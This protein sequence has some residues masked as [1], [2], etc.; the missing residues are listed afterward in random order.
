MSIRL[1]IKVMLRRK[2]VTALLLLQLA[3]TLAL[4]L[5]SIVLADQ[6][7]ER[8]QEPTGLSLANTLVVQ[9]K[10]TVSTLR[11]YPA[12]GELLER[13]MA[14]LR[15]IPG[16][17][18][19]AYA[20]QPPLLWGGN[21]GNIYKIGDQERNNISMVPQYYTSADIFAVLGLT[22][23]AG[24]L[25]QPLLSSTSSDKGG[26][27]ITQSVAKRLFHGEEAI[28]QATNQGTIAAVVSD[29][30]GQR[31]ADG[32][33]YNSIFVAPL[34]GVDWGYTLLLRADPQQ[35]ASVRLQLDTVLRQVDS[36]IEIF[37]IRTLQEQHQNLYKTESGLALLLGLLSALMLLVTMISGYSNAH[38]HVLKSQQEIG[39]KRALGASKMSILF[40][41]LAEGWLST[42]LGGLLGVVAAVL[43]NQ[44]LALVISIPAL[45]IGLV[46]FTLVLLLL[47]VTLAT[48]YPARIAT[49][50]SPATATKTM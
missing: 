49:Q 33:M 21:N 30:Y 14:A 34:Y 27:V 22:T 6:T 20:N 2:V 35:V 16:V 19:V 28:G 26:V 50:V 48:W 9:M 47:C 1:M 25:P 43:L 46:L 5:N 11:R 10:P 45:N 44:A 38:F 23:Q 15:Q 40:E 31:S 24:V 37:Y 39:I 42:V 18:A 17:V 32:V 36:N 3:L 29:F 7:Y 12:L 41:L 4:I 13:Q 8:L